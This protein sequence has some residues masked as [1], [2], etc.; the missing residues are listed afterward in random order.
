[1]RDAQL[2]RDIAGS[3]AVVRQFDDPLAD[4]VGKW[5]TVDEDAAQLVDTSVTCARRVVHCS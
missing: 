2:A 4:H 5:P 3:D 1:V